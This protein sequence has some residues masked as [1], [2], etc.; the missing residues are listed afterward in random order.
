[1]QACGGDDVSGANR[2]VDGSVDGPG[3]GDAAATDA[4]AQTDGTSSGGEYHDL[5]NAAS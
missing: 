4:L 1:V 2:G 3:A 5:A